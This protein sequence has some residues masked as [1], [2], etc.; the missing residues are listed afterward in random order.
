MGFYSINNNKILYT[1]FLLRIINI[2]KLITI[3][4]NIMN[5]YSFHK[6]NLP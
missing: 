2:I 4:L 3:P 5:K 1:L 6:E